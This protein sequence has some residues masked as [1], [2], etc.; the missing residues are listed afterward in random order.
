M[1][2]LVWFYDGQLS[3]RKEWALRG[4]SSVW[5]LSKET[6]AIFTQGNQGS[7]KTSKNPND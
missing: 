1:K 5:G 3:A 7:K 4:K 6:K 2:V